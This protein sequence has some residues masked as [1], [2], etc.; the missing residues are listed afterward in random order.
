MSECQLSAFRRDGTNPSHLTERCALFGQWGMV[1]DPY[2]SLNT[3]CRGQHTPF[4]I[5]K[6]CHLCK[7]ID[8]KDSSSW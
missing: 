7:L 1:G 6:L 3:Q 8:F 4:L 5:L 2:Y